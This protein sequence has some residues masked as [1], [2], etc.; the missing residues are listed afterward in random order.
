MTINE[1]KSM[2]SV[3]DYAKA[4]GVSEWWVR[5]LC[6]N[7]KIDCLKVGQTWFIEN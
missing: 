5:K 3:E 4:K 2:L 6:R 1:L 7:G